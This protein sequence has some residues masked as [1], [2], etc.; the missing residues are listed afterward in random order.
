MPSISFLQRYRDPLVV[1]V[2]LVLPFVFYVSNSKATRNHNVAD[3]VVVFLSAPVQWL[4]VAT[5]DGVTSVWRQYVAL[6]GVEA[7]NEELRAEN[8][9]LREE[10]LHT[11]RDPARAGGCLRRLPRAGLLL[12]GRNSEDTGRFV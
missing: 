9:R 10:L 4:V 12:I 8:A 5:L 11:V 1:L 3:R 2:L 7:E 6:V